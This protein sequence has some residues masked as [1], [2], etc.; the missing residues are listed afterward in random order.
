MIPALVIC[1]FYDT[2]SRPFL[3]QV[4]LFS[5]SV[6][7]LHT[8]LKARNEHILQIVAWPQQRA[9][10][11]CCPSGHCTSTVA[12]MPSLGSLVMFLTHLQPTQVSVFCFM[13]LFFNVIYF[14]Y[15]S[16]IRYLGILNSVAI[17]SLRLLLKSLLNWKVWLIIPTDLDILE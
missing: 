8:V 16:P 17:S 2:V 3:H 10:D 7:L 15:D 6:F 9:G 4:F 5:F 1:S 12:K 11:H 14:K 13:L